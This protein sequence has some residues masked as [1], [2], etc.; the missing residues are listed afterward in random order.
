MKYA[1]KSFCRSNHNLKKIHSYL[2]KVLIVNLLEQRRMWMKVWKKERKKKEEKKA[3]SPTSLRINIWI[4]FHSLYIER[5]VEEMLLKWGKEKW[6]NEIYIYRE[7]NT[8]Q[9]FILSDEGL[10][11]FFSFLFFKLS[12]TFSFVLTIP[13]LKF[14]KKIFEDFIK[15]CINKGVI[16]L[17]PLHSE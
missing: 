2:K 10:E 15:L 11:A 13:H 5:K 7:W 14:E 16:Q 3:S 4:M 8:I 1:K 9:V 6:R 12:S 17:E